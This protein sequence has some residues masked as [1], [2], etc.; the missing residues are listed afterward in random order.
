MSPSLNTPANYWVNV[1]K[2][3]VIELG[4]SCALEI[5]SN[6]GIKGGYV[7]S[8]PST[9]KNISTTTMPMVTKRGSVVTYHEWF[10]PSQ[11]HDPL[12]TWSC[13]ITWQTKFITP[14]PEWR[15]PSNLAGWFNLPWWAS[16]QRVIWPFQHVVVI[17]HVEN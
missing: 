1:L 3:G 9:T 16:T 13:E 2:F 7:E 6:G 15:Q 11:P 8:C 14:L 17:D 5:N 4:M 12:I 10:L